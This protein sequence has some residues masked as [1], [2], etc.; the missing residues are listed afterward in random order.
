MPDHAA[1][2][3][4]EPGAAASAAFPL[5]AAMEEIGRAARDI[6]FAETADVIALGRIRILR[7]MIAACHDEVARTHDFAL[8]RELTAAIDGL[9]LELAD[10]E[11]TLPLERAFRADQRDQAV[12]QIHTTHERLRAFVA[13]STQQ[14]VLFEPALSRAEA[15]ELALEALAQSPEDII[16]A[17]RAEAETRCADATLPMPAESGLRFTRSEGWTGWLAARIAERA[18]RALPG[19]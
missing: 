11:D 6:A 4:A 15:V 8:T 14:A 17:A 3:Q 10:F 1:R 7:D 9:G 16:A 18:G 12:A 5:E 2:P 19:I 13:D